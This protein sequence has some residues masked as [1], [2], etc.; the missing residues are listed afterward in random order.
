MENKQK[1]PETKAGKLALVGRCSGSGGENFGEHGEGNET[2]LELFTLT[3]Y[4]LE[5]VEEFNFNLSD[6]ING[7]YKDLEKQ[8]APVVL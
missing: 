4:N 7:G 8:F 5:K 2:K 6:Y 1:W 3:F